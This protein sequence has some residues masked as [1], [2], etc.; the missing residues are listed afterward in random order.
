MSKKSRRRPARQT[1][2][3]TATAQKASEGS[4]KP[5]G[6]PQ[7]V[8]ATRSPRPGRG[9]SLG[10][11]ILILALVGGAISGYLAYVHYRGVSA[12]CLPGMEC[13]EVLSSAYAQFA[14]VPLS[15]LGLG[16]YV[17]LAVLGFLLWWGSGERRQWFAL[18]AYAVALSATLF[19]LYLYYLEI[20][21][22][23]A[24]CTWCVASS[25]VVFALMVLTSVSLYR[26]TRSGS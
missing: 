2:R 18:A 12:L 25:L 14:G 22:I 9:G 1:P 5:S 4:Q 16:M 24:F 15:L 6:A 13:D 19:S 21:E 17:V 23:E 11:V 3:P 8:T 7:K 10:L 20:F 26:T